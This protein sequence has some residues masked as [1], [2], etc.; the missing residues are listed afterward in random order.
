[1]QVLLKH[2]FCSS[3][4]SF[5]GSVN[6]CRALES[7]PIT[8]AQWFCCGSAFENHRSRASPLRPSQRS[9]TG[10]EPHANLLRN[11]PSSYTT[12]P[13]LRD[14][15]SGCG[16]EWVRLTCSLRSGLNWLV[17]S[18]R[19]HPENRLNMWAP[20][21]SQSCENLS[22][23]QPRPN[24]YLLNLIKFNNHLLAST[25]KGLCKC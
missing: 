25:F 21:F 19:L 10:G 14:F 7:V 11:S 8:S 15:P 1:M 12:A 13:P 23:V 24:C 2:N 22:L 5:Q 6:R 9:L 4:R 18:W 3:I 20:P 16:Q 17:H